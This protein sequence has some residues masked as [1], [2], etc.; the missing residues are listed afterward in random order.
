MR[1]LAILFVLLATLASVYDGLLAT[2]ASAQGSSTLEQANRCVDPWE[3]SIPKCVEFK[4][5]CEKLGGA[6]HV[7]AIWRAFFVRCRDP[8]TGKPISITVAFSEG[9]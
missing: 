4:A 5:A 3:T 7:E 9:F 1:K 6:F 8:K 2:P